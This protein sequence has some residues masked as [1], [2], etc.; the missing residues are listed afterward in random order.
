MDELS[1]LAQMGTEICDLI[2]EI[3]NGNLKYNYYL[4]ITPEQ[5]DLIHRILRKLTMKYSSTEFRT[6]NYYCHI[7]RRKKSSFHFCFHNNPPKI[8]DGIIR[9]NPFQ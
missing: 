7:T 6:D 5:E 2:C 3:K 1:Q 9:G 4:P 8:W